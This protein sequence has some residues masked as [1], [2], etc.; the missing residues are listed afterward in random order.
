MLSQNDV[1]NAYLL[2]FARA[3]QYPSKIQKICYGP[4]LHPHLG[5]FVFAFE[6]FPTHPPTTPHCP[7][8]TYSHIHS[9]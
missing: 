1:G 2:G 5:F 4:H 3:M 9:N 6:T 7:P 8:L